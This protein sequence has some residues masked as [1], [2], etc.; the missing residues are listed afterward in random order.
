MTL[1]TNRSMW[2]ALQ[3][4]ETSKGS[5][6]LA[7]TAYGGWGFHSW[8]IAGF[9]Y[10]Y[11]ATEANAMVADG[12]V[13]NNPVFN[14]GYEPMLVTNATSDEVMYAIAKYV[15]AVSSAVG[16][17]PVFGDAL[18]ENNNLTSGKYRNGWG[19][20]SENGALLWKHSD[21]K[22]M[23]YYYAYKLYEEIIQKGALK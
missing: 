22:D 19:R 11:S 16:G 8:R 23:A 10:T 15:P 3:K 9:D 4:Q 13:T 20:A 5:R 2:L 1:R 12:S 6:A 17:N 7:G 14:R 18:N 21:M